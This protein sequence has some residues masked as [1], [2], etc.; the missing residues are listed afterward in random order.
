MSNCYQYNSQL[1]HEYYVVNSNS[2][3]KRMSAVE[4]LSTLISI[5]PQL[6]PYKGSQVWSPENFKHTF[7]IFQ[8][9]SFSTNR[10]KSQTWKKIWRF[11]RRYLASF[12]QDFL[13]YLQVWR[14]SIFPALHH[15]VSLS[16]LFGLHFVSYFKYTLGH[17][18]IFF[19]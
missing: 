10:L 11:G 9:T 15:P 5:Y 2:H 19:K 3:R 16:L 4:L 12:S 14:I 7:L 17:N 6:T 18:C 8:R 1:L 13:K